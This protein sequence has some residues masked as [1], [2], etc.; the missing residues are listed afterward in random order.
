MPPS[1]FH[2]KYDGGTRRFASRSA[3][4]APSVAGSLLSLDAARVPA[5]RSLNV[6]R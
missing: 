5:R 3:W 4:F 1:Y 2:K 6:H